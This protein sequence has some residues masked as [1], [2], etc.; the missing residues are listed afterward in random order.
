MSETTV[1]VLRSDVWLEPDPRRV[2]LRA[3]L[4]GGRNPDDGRTRVEHILDRVLG[5]S[6]DDAARALAD[7]RDR[8][9]ERHPDLDQVLRDSAERLSAMLPDR[10]GLSDD[11]RE[12]VG[13]YFLH[14]YAVEA[15]ALTNPSL[16]AAP[17][18]SQVPDGWL[19][20]VLSLRAI[21]EGHLS[22]IEFLT[23]L[24]AP[25]GHVELEPP[26][27][28]VAGSR[29]PAV[30]DRAVFAARLREIGSLN[31]GGLATQV[32]G[33]L[34]DRFT[35]TELEAALAEL[36]PASASPAAS[37]HAVHTMH[38]LA[39]SN[40][41]LTFPATSQISQR[42]IFPA[43]PAESNGMEDARFVRFEE[44]DGEVVHYA[45]YTAFDGFD[46]LPQ[47]IE[48]PD[49]VSFRIATLSGPSA[50]NKGMAI[51]PR[52]IGGRYAALGRADNENNY[53][54]LSDNLRLWREA[55]RIQ[56]PTRPW[57]L[58]Q[59]G[60]CG[61]PIETSDGWLVI[62]HGVGPMRT[63]AL[64]AILLD[65]D[66]PS[67][68]LGHLDEPLLV[69]DDRERDGYVPNVVYSCGSLVHAGRLVIAYGASD[70]TTAFAS[71]DLD[72]LL[73]ALQPPDAAG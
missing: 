2:L 36:G 26:E 29:R 20:V 73:G 37:Q 19:R 43:G 3:F 53:L 32:L 1:P 64:G 14:E 7:V 47:L 66:D 35:L 17:D 16:V 10:A 39:A 68:V 54:M 18:Q 46:V 67:R 30:F 52:R 13:A 42:V 34:A 27:A 38:W 70:R 45:T 9:G 65:L 24:V 44:P 72:T 55:Q 21:G 15:A 11:R 12:L 33:R 40:Y 60:N 28:P 59:I 25:D 8:F 51:F 49:F 5:L 6:P 4:P 22:S 41:E 56:V 63:Y 57:E 61:P 71:V 23:G 62:T 50:R 48:T 31:S 58:V 69:P